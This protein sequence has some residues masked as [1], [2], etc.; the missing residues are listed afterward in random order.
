[1]YGWVNGAA[2]YV[3]DD[4]TQDTVWE[5]ARPA[6]SEVHPVMKPVE[7]VERAIRTSS[8]PGDLIYD[9]FLGSGTTLIAAEKSA[10]T[11]YGIELE[12]RYAQVVIERWQDFTGERATKLTDQVDG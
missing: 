11:C 10:R 7:L 4:R 5:V 2:H 8:R 9:P 12:P 3:I 6:R 1:L